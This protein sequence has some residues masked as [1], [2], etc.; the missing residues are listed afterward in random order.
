MNAAK[1]VLGVLVG[2]AVGATAGILFAPDKGS[3]TRKKI[4]N[5]RDDYVDELE[6]KFN[7]FVDGVTE[8]FEAVKSEATRMAKNGKTKMDEIETKVTAAAN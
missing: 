5:K 6:E 7:T 8:K 4:S 3:T 2:F 1:V